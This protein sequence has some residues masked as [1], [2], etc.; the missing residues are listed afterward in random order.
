MW[1]LHFRNSHQP[2]PTNVDPTFPVGAPDPFRRFVFVSN[3]YGGGKPTTPPVRWGF[4]GYKTMTKW[5]H[6]RHP[7]FEALNGV[8][9]P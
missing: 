4:V 8:I 9:A 2:T 1:T 5:L 6:Y 3:S 7:V